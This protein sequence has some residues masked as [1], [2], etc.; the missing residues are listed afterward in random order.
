MLNSLPSIALSLFA[1]GNLLWPTTGGWI[2]LVFS[3]CLVL[4]FSS[5]RYHLRANIRENI[6]IYLL[7]ACA[8]A[9]IAGV[10]SIKLPPGLPAIFVAAGLAGMMILAIILILSGL[11]ILFM[12]AKSIK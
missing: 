5:A 2:I 7:F 6:G 11:L 1:A 12:R 3:I 10:V 9:L 4:R 8:Y